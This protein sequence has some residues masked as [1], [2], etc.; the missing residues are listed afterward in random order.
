MVKQ[1]ISDSARIPYQ[2]ICLHTLEHLTPCILPSLL[3]E[4]GIRKLC[5]FAFQNSPKFIYPSP[6]EV[7]SFLSC[8]GRLLHLLRLLITTLVRDAVLFSC[9]WFSKWHTTTFSA[10][11]AVGNLEEKGVRENQFLG[12]KLSLN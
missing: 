7:V 10:C 8:G 12:S 6:T 3:G 9:L 4:L 2:V 5:T 1:L 11:S